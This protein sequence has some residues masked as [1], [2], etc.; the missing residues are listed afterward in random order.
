MLIETAAENGRGDIVEHLLDLALKNNYAGVAILLANH[1]APMD[2]NTLFT[3]LEYNDEDTVIELVK[4][5]API[6]DEFIEFSIEE[7]SSLELVKF[8][9][10]NK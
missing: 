1:G 4:L 6:T 9:M 10:E 8:L 5:G 3:A 2:S 7:D